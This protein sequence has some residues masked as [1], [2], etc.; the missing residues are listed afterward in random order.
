[1]VLYHGEEADYH[2]FVVPEVVDGQVVSEQ[3]VKRADKDGKTTQV[4]HHAKHYA[5][6]PQ[7]VEFEVPCIGY[8]HDHYAPSPTP[9]NA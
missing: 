1:M 4:H 7:T 8:D 5:G 9:P 6:K 3:A 2:A